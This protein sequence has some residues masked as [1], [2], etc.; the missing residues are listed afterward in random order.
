[1]NNLLLLENYQRDA[2]CFHLYEYCKLLLRAFSSNLQELFLDV[3]Y[4]LPLI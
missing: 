2:I 4:F 3:Y 1:M